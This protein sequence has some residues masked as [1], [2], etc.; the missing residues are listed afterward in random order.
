MGIGIAATDACRCGGDGWEV[1]LPG[2]S[3]DLRNRRFEIL[4]MKRHAGIGGPHFELFLRRLW[5]VVNR[6]YLRSKKRPCTPHEPLQVPAM[7]R[8]PWRGLH[9]T[10][11]VRRHP[12]LGEG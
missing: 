10:V 6:R 2:I 12:R 11:V 8:R 5:K 3:A 7:R 1:G 9:A 4:S